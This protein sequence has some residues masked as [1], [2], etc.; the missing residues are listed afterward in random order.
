[1]N[2]GALKCVEKEKLLIMK[3]FSLLL[4][5][6]EHNGMGEMRKSMR[7]DEAF[8]SS[9]CWVLCEFLDEFKGIKL[10]DKYLR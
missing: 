2:S 1:M 8:F 10:I 7:F 4:P 9:H 6:T 3:F 5:S